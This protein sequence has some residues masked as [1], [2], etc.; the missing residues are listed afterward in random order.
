[1]PG[2]SRAVLLKWKLLVSWRSGLWNGYLC[3]SCTGSVNYQFLIHLLVHLII[4]EKY[5]YY[6]YQNKDISLTVTLLHCGSKEGYCLSPLKPES[7]GIEF[8]EIGFILTY[9]VLKTLSISCV[10][11]WNKRLLKIWTADLLWE[12]TY[13]TFS[14][15]YVSVALDTNFW[16]RNHQIGTSEK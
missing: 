2:I 11:L 15:W 1:M 4:T 3:R 8:R 6:C 14:A 9:T 16:K 12:E 10:G 13:F 7:E 5:L